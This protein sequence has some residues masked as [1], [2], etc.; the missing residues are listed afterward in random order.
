TWG[1]L[2]VGSGDGLSTGD[3]AGAGRGRTDWRAASGG[4]GRSRPG[5]HRRARRS[6]ERVRRPRRIRRHGSSPGDRRRRGQ[7]RAGRAAGMVPLATGSDG[8]GSLRIPASLCGLSCLKPSLGRVPTGGSHA[9]DWHHLSTR[10]LLART[11]DDL[12]QALDIV[13]GPDPTDLRSL[14]MPE[15]SWTAAVENAHVPFAV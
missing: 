4:A 3:V 7:R 12:V 6:G 13:I 14:P 15:A 2:A 8:G 10:G 9:P 11:V 1:A 5:A